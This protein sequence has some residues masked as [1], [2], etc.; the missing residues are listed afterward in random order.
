[1]SYAYARTLHLIRYNWHFWLVKFLSHLRDDASSRLSGYWYEVY[2]VILMTV[3]LCNRRESTHAIQVLLRVSYSHHSHNNWPS[4]EIFCIT[5]TKQAVR[6]ISKCSSWPFQWAE[7]EQPALRS[8]LT[9]MQLWF[10]VLS[11]DHNSL[12]SNLGNDI[13][14]YTYCTDVPEISQFW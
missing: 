14:V 12:I 6:T 7:P 10:L 1:M 3:I 11:K 4:W 13:P 2:S 9:Y 8:W 5:G